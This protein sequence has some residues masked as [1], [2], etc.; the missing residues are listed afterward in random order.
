MPIKCI[1]CSYDANRDSARF[2]R[3]CGV[4]L[5]IVSQPLTSQ[6]QTPLQPV[7]PPGKQVGLPQPYAQP[8]VVPT[9]PTQK[10]APWISLPPAVVP[11]RSAGPIVAGTVTLSRERRDRPPVD[12]YRIIFITS[13]VL[14]FWPAI[15]VGIVVL[16]LVPA[17]AI[18][19]SIFLNLFRRPSGPVEVPVYEISVDDTVNRRVINV[20]MIG[21]RGGGNIEVGDDVEVFGQWVNHALQNNVRAWE[22]HITHR[23]S[24]I[25]GKKVHSGAVIQAQRPF[26]PLLAI[27]S[28][29][30]SLVG[31]LWAC[32]AFSV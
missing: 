24:P 28:M 25:Q 17:V 7:V 12:W 15:A 3:Q 14:L 10:P 1:H 16:C 27:G 4:R 20:E 22:I 9:P 30:V 26:P 19:I 29:I 13:M 5:T 11:V 31:I 21:Q 18:A 32:G 8:L 2:C 23:Y 6:P